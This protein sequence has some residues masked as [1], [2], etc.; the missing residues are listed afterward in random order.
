MMKKGYLEL[1]VKVKY[2]LCMSRLFNT[3]VTAD[4]IEQQSSSFAPKDQE[5]QNQWAYKTF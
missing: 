1:R 2:C 3:T 5:I 4:E